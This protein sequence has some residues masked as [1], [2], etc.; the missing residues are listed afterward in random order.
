MVLL[1]AFLLSFWIHLREVGRE[2]LQTVL[3]F[4]LFSYFRNAALRTFAGKYLWRVWG[5]CCINQRRPRA[6]GSLGRKQNVPRNGLEIPEKLDKNLFI[7]VGPHQGPKKN[8]RFGKTKYQKKQNFISNLD[9]ILE[10]V[11]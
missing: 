2:I 8:E 11:E 1:W 10:D 5:N 3:L 9:V 7:K 4:S 6:E